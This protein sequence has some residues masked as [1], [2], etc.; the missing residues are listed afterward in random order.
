MDR[1]LLVESGPRHLI[2][3]LAPFLRSIY[4]KE[5]VFDLITCYPDHPS[6][7]T[8]ECTWQV[9]AYRDRASRARLF[10]E[11]RRRR[12]SALVM[13]CAGVPIMT[14]WKWA[15]AVR[16]RAKVLVVNENGDCFWLDRAHWPAIRR[17]VLFRAGLSGPGAVGALFRIAAFPFTLAYLL[18][19]AAYLHGRRLILGLA[20]KRLMRQPGRREQRV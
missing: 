18:G 19:Y 5:T 13:L 14:K 11:L 8:P 7:L 4:P 2:E 16:L 6:G 15:L 12:Y 1:V 10:G 9:V 17:F 20:A 3:G